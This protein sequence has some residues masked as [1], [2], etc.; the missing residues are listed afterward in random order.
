MESDRNSTLTLLQPELL[1]EKELKEI[2][3]SRCVSRNLNACNKDELV[4]LFRSIALPLPQREYGDS[5]REKLLSKKQQK[6][7]RIS[8]SNNDSNGSGVLSSKSDEERKPNKLAEEKVSERLK[9]PPDQINFQ[10]KVIR[11][12]DSAK[13]RI[14]NELD[15]IVIKNKQAKEMNNVAISKED[16]S[17]AKRLCTNAE[18]NG[19]QDIV[20][21]NNIVPTTAVKLKRNSLDNNTD[22]ET[23]ENK[24]SEEEPS[25]KKRQKIVISW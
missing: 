25:Q 18:V 9:P 7:R 3:I 23:E 19:K 5:R 17:D 2:L 8:I 14:N 1:N 22:Q 20:I 10:R 6:R 21:K 12:S 15:K 11:L 13:K 4:E 16:S 24:K